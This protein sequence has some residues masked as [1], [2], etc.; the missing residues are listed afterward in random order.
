MRHRDKCQPEHLWEASFY[1]P[2]KIILVTHL[3]LCWV[4]I[5]ALAC[6]RCRE[7]GY[8]LVSLVAGSGGTLWLGCSGLA[9][10]QLVRSSQTLD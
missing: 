8:A 4:F 2:L 9:A 10:L 7:W 3:W 6:S 1:L 5:A